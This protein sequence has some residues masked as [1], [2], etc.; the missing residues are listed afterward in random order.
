[1]LKKL[2]RFKCKSAKIKNRKALALLELILKAT[3][4]NNSNKDPLIISP[5]QIASLDIKNPYDKKA[6]L[7]YLQRLQAQGKLILS[8]DNTHKKEATQKSPSH[9][10]YKRKAIDSPVKKSESEQEL[11]KRALLIKS[12]FFIKKHY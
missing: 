1:M 6:T 10:T 7:Y 8:E 4:S 12:K 5:D 11:Q 2:P 3:S 9:K